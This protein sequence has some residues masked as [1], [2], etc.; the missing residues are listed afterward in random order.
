V[1]LEDLVRLGDCSYPKISAEAAPLCARG[2]ALQFV[3]AASKFSRLCQ[4]SAIRPVVERI[5][6][7]SEVSA[8]LKH[9][10]AGHSQGLSVV[11]ISG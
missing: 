7:L 2:Q 8:A 9:V 1:K 4:G 5:W 3:N 10:G 11:R 6:S